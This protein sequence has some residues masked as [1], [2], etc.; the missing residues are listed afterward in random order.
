KPGGR[1]K[2]SPGPFDYAQGRLSVLGRLIFWIPSRL[3]AGDTVRQGRREGA[4]PEGSRAL[5]GTRTQRSQPALSV[6]EGPWATIVPPSGLGI[7]A[8]HPKQNRLEWRTWQARRVGHRQ[9]DGP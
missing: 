3:P 8:S 4:V 2:R 5:R 1:H 6:V 9:V 7:S